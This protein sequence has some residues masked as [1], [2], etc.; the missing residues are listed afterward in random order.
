MVLAKT[1]NVA[2]KSK[3]FQVGREL[4]MLCIKWRPFCAKKIYVECTVAELVFMV[5][6]FKI[7][8]IIISYY[9]NIIYVN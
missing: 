4:L 8:N 5:Y 3:S 1:P 7:I 9:K 2:R 6:N